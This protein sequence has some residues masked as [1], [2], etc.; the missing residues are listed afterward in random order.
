[1]Q[2]LIRFVRCWIFTPL[3]YVDL[4][5]GDTIITSG[6]SHIF[7]EGIMIGT[8]ENV[9][10]TE[11]LFKTARVKFSVD[12]NRLYYGYI[13]QDAQKEELDQLNPEQ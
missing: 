5:Q 8:V 3:P 9:S 10:G 4:Q 12:Y 7:P 1:M 11:Q 13:I 6:N 2:G